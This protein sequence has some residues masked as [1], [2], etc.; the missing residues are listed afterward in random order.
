[1]GARA[2]LNDV[3]HSTLRR[4]RSLLLLLLQRRCFVEHA[5][6]TAYV[7]DGLTLRRLRC[8]LILLWRRRFVQTWCVQPRLV[9]VVVKIRACVDVHGQLLRRDVS[10]LRQA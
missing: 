2:N 10:C 1:V 9:V 4:L 5:H 6:A 3:N 7:V 8:L